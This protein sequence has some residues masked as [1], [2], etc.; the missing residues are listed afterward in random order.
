MNVS[1]NW[2]WDRAI[3]FLG[4]FQNS[5]RNL[6]VCG[7]GGGEGKTERGPEYPSVC[8]LFAPCTWNCELGWPPA[9]VMSACTPSQEA[10]FESLR[11]TR[12]RCTLPK[13]RCTHRVT[14]KGVQPW[15]NEDS[16][17]RAFFYFPLCSE[18]KDSEVSCTDIALFC[19]KRHPWDSQ[20]V[21]GLEKAHFRQKNRILA[22][23]RAKVGI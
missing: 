19:R 22:C 2:D 8:F 18:F 13:Y 21:P 15:F 7:R 14:Y 20:C 16:E 3:P 6:F 5:S 23:G 9:M 1:E 10:R 17:V 11:P 4:I 12:L